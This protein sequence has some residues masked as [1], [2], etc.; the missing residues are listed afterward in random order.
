MTTFKEFLEEPLNEAVLKPWKQ[1]DLKVKPAI[2]I[3]NAECKDGLKAIQT[4]GLLYRGFDGGKVE[5]D[6]VHL[7]STKAIRTSRD[8]NNLYQ[9]MMDVSPALEGFSKR[10]NSFICSSNLGAASCYASIGSLYVMIPVDGT[11]IVVSNEVDFIANPMHNLLNDHN[12]Q[13]LGNEMSTFLRWLGMKPDVK[14]GK[15]TDAKTIN[16]ILATFS[17]EVLLLAAS[18]AFNQIEL[19]D[20][21]FDSVNDIDIMYVWN[22]ISSYNPLTMKSTRQRVDILEQFMRAKP[23][24]K[25]NSGKLYSL[26]SVHEKDRFTAIAGLIMTPST[27]KLSITQFG[28]KLS[29]DVECWFSG[30]TIAIK[31]DLF[32]LILHELQKQKFKIHP[33]ILAT[34]NSRLHNDRLNPEDDD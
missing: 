7:D 17:P 31:A 2:A 12:L 32:A 13:D 33:S 15:W 4:G 1:K 14:S 27:L 6:F 21:Y 19:Q 34:W 24:K 8:T 16:A 26:F 5:G 29:K 18:V 9:L 30:K 28:S 20:D 3:L 25:G 10:S 22:N 11:K 23:P